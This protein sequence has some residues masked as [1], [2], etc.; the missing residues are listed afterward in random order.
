MAPPP[1]YPPKHD[2]PPAARPRDEGD[3]D[4]LKVTM[5]DYCAWYEYLLNPHEHN[6][7]ARWKIE[8]TRSGSSEQ[9]V[10]KRTT[11]KSAESH[12]FETWTLTSVLDGV[13][14]QAI[15][16]APL[17]FA[18][19]S[20]DVIEP[21]YNGF[22]NGY[23]VSG[24]GATSTDREAGRTSDTEY[25]MLL[26]L[27]TDFMEMRKGWVEPGNDKAHDW[28][29]AW[30]RFAVGNENVFLVLAEG[31][32]AY[33]ASYLQF[34]RGLDD[35]VRQLVEGFQNKHEAP[36]GS[37]VSG[38]VWKVVAVASVG[39]V[40]GKLVPGW[41]QVVSLALAA[42][43]AG[44]TEYAK[45]Q[46]PA[47]LQ[48]QDPGRWADFVMA[49]DTQVRAHMRRFAQDIDSIR[50][51]METRVAAVRDGHL[52]NPPERD[53]SIKDMPPT[54]R[55]IVPAHLNDGVTRWLDT[56]VADLTTNC[57]VYQSAV[58]TLASADWAT[59]SSVFPEVATARERFASRVRELGQEAVDKHRTAV[60][61]L[62]Q[63]G[64]DLR[65]VANNAAAN[66]E[67]NLQIVNNLLADVQAI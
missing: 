13:D 55:E 66:E 21:A 6:G 44:A 54:R 36:D 27:I 8:D 33:Q 51:S 18:S 62:R 29:K 39:A 19:S 61:R 3:N 52:A 26:P 57:T 59:P 9:E 46:V 45:R 60:E 17:V 65:W 16:N 12:P 43:V 32:V 41:G 1:G 56:K 48:V 10:N 28:E 11:D 58:D 35:A 34:R 2:A 15:Y 30:A 4:Q 47:D 67:A 63:Y 22:S 31:L 23:L 20:P 5:A 49:A 53:E 42:A 37:S 25:E 7:P 38:F 14:P 24:S 64:E 50:E 40:A